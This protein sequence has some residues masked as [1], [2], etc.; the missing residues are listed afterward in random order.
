V[1]Y[2]GNLN[3]F[4]GSFYCVYFFN[5]VRHHIIFIFNTKRPISSFFLVK[6]CKK[7]WKFQRS[8]IILKPFTLKCMCTL[9]TWTLLALKRKPTSFLKQTAWKD[10]MKRDE[11]TKTS[12]PKLSWGKIGTKHKWKGN[13][14][15]KISSYK[16]LKCSKR[17]SS[18]LFPCDHLQSAN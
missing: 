7:V 5:I 4:S 16:Q 11:T 18:N 2:V 1:H 14:C 6:C 3:N 13:S 8:V 15:L 9:Q 17:E 12:S 10:K